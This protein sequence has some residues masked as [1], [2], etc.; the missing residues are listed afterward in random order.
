MY[1][2]DMVVHA[3]AASLADGDQVNLGDDRYRSL[4]VP[5]EARCLPLAVSFEQAVAELEQLARMVVEPDGALVWTGEHPV[6]GRII[7]W[8]VDGTLYDRDDRLM[9][10]ELAG[11]VPPDQFDRLLAAL[12][13]PGQPVMFQDK[14]RGVFLDENE[15]RRFAVRA[16]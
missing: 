6:D 9:H 7:R 2:F 8:Q 5:P 15:F 13:W 4:R 14:K 11:R 1:H 10:V 12:G 3:R 16:M